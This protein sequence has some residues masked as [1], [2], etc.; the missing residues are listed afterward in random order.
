MKLFFT[1]VLRAPGSGQQGVLPSESRRLEQANN[2]VTMLII[3]VLCLFLSGDEAC[4]SLFSL[5]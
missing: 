2:G 4:R 1:L 3:K 5:S